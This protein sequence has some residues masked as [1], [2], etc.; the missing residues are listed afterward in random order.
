MKKKIH[1]IST[2]RADFGLI[3]NLILA[4]KKIKNL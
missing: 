4:L 3:K 2:N 1:I